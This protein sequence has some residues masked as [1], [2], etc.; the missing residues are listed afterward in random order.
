VIPVALFAPIL[1]GWL[2]LEG[3]RAGLFGLEM[4]TGGLVMA[5]VASL[6]ALTAMTAR[7]LDAADRARRSV[8]AELQRSL[9]RHS[10]LLEGNLIGV[11]SVSP[12]GLIVEANPAFLTLLGY[13]REDLPLVPDAITPPEWR[14]L[15]DTARRE[16]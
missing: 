1:F 13:G 15:S 3:Q 9:V 11:L 14:G 5:L 12:A 8:E 6:I 16:V 4:G 2:R 10:R 7:S